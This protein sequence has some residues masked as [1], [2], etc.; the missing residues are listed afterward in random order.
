MGFWSAIGGALKAVGGL[1]FG[2]TGR[3]IGW[4]AEKIFNLGDTPS[5]NS[6]TATV[7]ETK[8]VNELL[9]KCIQGYSKEAEEYDKLAQNII[10]ANFYTIE[11]KLSEIN[12]ASDKPII[13]N[14]VFESFKSNTKNINKS[15]NKIYSKQISNTFS[16]NNNKLLDILK[17]DKGNKKNDKLRDLAVDTVTKANNTLLCELSDFTKEQQNFI[18]GKLSEYMT[19]RKNTLMTSKNETEKILASLEKD[20]NERTQLKNYYGNLLN[21]INLLGKIL[22]LGGE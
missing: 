15:L 8:K 19:N 2:G 13:D 14:F 11:E 6:S 20:D 4:L 1:L 22:N 3:V 9:E 5:Y 18:S 21:E 10:K 16:L 12:K 7:D 17:L